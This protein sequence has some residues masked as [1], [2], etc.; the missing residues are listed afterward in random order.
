L[1]ILGTVT[2]IINQQTNAELMMGIPQF[3]SCLPI[4]LANLITGEQVGGT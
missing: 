3:V 4:V 1:T 2:I